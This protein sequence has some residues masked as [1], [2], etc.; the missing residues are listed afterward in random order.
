MCRKN[1]VF[2][3][4]LDARPSTKPPRSVTF[5]RPQGKSEPMN[6]GRREP[7]F[8]WQ[9]S[10]GER[11]AEPR[12]A[13]AAPPKVLFVLFFFVGGVSRLFVAFFRSVSR[14]FGL[15][16]APWRRANPQCVG[17]TLWTMQSWDDEELKIEFRVDSDWAKGTDRIATSGGMMNN[18]PNCGE[19]LVED[20]TDACLER[21]RVSVLHHRHRDS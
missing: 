14:F 2:A 6:E 7:G 5:G 18:Q 12:R 20:T 21:G 19:A 1:D 8:R 3:L 9:A 16:V 10:R 17:V 11:R 4:Q 13:S 15:L